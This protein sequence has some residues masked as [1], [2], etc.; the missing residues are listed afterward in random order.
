[1]KKG[2]RRATGYNMGKQKVVGGKK[3]RSFPG[4]KNAWLQKLF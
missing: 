3:Q 1:M 4:I 2:G